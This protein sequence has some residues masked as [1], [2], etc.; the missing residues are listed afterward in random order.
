MACSRQS[1]RMLPGEA[2]WWWLRVCC[3]A[4]F[5]YDLIYLLAVSPLYPFFDSLRESCAHSECLGP[6]Y[7]VSPVHAEGHTL[8]F[9]SSS[10]S[11][12]HLLQER[13][14]RPY[15]TEHIHMHGHTV[16][17]TH[18]YA[19]A[20]SCTKTTYCK[21][22]GEHYSSLSW[23]PSCSKLPT[24]LACAHPHNVPHSLVYGLISVVWTSCRVGVQPQPLLLI[25]LHPAQ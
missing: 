8:S 4:Q 24:V 9:P 1:R 12:Q 14:E 21:S 23:A 10:V 18:P 11:P 5:N 13:R 20:H 6:L 2:E 3:H 22:S 19:Q 17:N 7:S 15:S 16:Y 25:P